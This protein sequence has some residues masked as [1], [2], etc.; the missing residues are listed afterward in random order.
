M[1]NLKNILQKIPVEK[2]IGSDNRSISS[3]QYDSRSVEQDSVFV[4][5]KG[6]VFDGHTFISKAINQGAVVIVCEELPEQF[7]A[8]IVCFVVYGQNPN[9]GTTNMAAATILAKKYKEE[10]PK[11]LTMFIGNS[12]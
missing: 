8:E 10:F 1:K 12:S 4:A 7:N 5:I 2:I 9:S 11:N 3:I 6:G